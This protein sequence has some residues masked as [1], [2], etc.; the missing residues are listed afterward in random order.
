MSYQATNYRKVFFLFNFPLLHAGI[1]Y[2]LKVH[3][4]MDKGYHTNILHLVLFNVSIYKP[5]WQ[6]YT[7][8]HIY[9]HMYIY[10]IPTADWH[11]SISLV[12]APIAAATNTPDPKQILGSTWYQR[13]LKKARN[14]PKGPFKL[15]RISEGQRCALQI[16]QSEGQW[17]NVGIGCNKN[18][19]TCNTWRLVVITL[20]LNAICVIMKLWMN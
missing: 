10:N 8:S 19:T 11:I 5:S 13:S 15:C 17:K 4:S 18:M 2:T 3:V 7:C 12:L 14:L 16:L 1:C 20:L 6:F 9:T